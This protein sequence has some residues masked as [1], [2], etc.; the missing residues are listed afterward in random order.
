MA[1]I[2]PQSNGPVYSNTLIGTLA[3]DGWDVTVLQRTGIQ[4]YGDWYTGR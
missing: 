4:Q 1:T 3:V 2:K